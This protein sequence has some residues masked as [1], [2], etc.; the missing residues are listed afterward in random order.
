M[1][2]DLMKDWLHSEYRDFDTVPRAMLCRSARGT[3]YFLSRFDASRGAYPDIYE[4]YRLP[5]LGEG[6]VCQSWFG[7]GFMT[8]GQFKGLLLTSDTSFAAEFDAERDL[9]GGAA[10]KL[11]PEQVPLARE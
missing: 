2:G 6:E 8:D 4:A 1:P 9:V 3:Y 5:P 10:P 7:L 11:V